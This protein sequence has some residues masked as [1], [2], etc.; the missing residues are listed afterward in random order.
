MSEADMIEKELEQINEADVNS[1]ID[2]SIQENKTL[3]FK[4]SLPGNSRAEREEFAADISSFANAS[5]GDIIFGVIEDREK[6]IPISLDGIDSKNIDQEILRLDNMMRDGIEPRI[7]NFRIKPITLS[8]SK[9]VLIIRI[10]KSWLAAHRNK[11]N[12]KFYSRSSN[13]KYPLDVSELRNAFILSETSSERIKKFLIDR[14]SVII[15]NETP[16]FLQETAKLALHLIPVNAFSPGQKYDL[17]VIAHNSSQIYP[18]RSSG[19]DHRYNLD[20]FLTYSNNE[21]KPYSYVQVFRNG[22]IEAVDT[23]ICKPT[24]I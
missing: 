13:G 8:N 1:I 3:E 10:P 4:Q 21:G 2:S 16:V 7:P 24:K 19:F 18:I 15:A 20:G 17:S 14:S 11:Y 23:E 5:G 9:K 12:D 22:I 6:G